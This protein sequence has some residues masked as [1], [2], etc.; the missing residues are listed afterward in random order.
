ME[1]RL[2][3]GSFVSVPTVVTGPS[4][5]QPAEAPRTGKVPQSHGHRRRG[6]G[7]PAQP[8]LAQQPR[9]VTQHDRGVIAATEFGQNV[10][11]PDLHQ[12]TS[13][14]RGFHHE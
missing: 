1:Q 6:G 10:I 14:W 5:V 8:N 11:R 13:G 9:V 3:S 2:A 7:H 12:L 4:A